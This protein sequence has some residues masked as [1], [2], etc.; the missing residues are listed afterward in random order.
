MSERKREMKAKPVRRGRRRGRAGARQ[1]QNGRRGRNGKGDSKDV[2]AP[3]AKT[4]VRRAQRPKVTP[5]SNGDSRVVH[6]E[7]IMD[8]VAGAGTPSAFAV[9]SLPVNPGQV[10]T[11]P[12]LS[13][14]AANYES[15]RF[16]SLRFCYETEASTALGGSLILAFDYDAADPA[17]TSK[18]QALMYRSSVRSAPWT[19]CEHKSILED[20]RKAKSNYV[21]PGAQP[22][23]TDVRQYDIGNFFAIS[24]G[25]STAGA[26]L[27][28]LYVEYNVVLMT[29][30]LEGSISAVFV[31]GT[32]G[33]DGTPTLANPFGDGVNQLQPFAYGF[34][35][36]SLSVLN[37]PNAGTYVISCHGT[38]TGI[39]GINFDPSV[40]AVTQVNQTLLASAL[41]G[42]WVV[43][44]VC[45]A[46]AT[47]GVDFTA[48]ATTI[49]ALE[50]WIGMAPNG[51]IV[52]IP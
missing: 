9:Q 21:R 5:F 30:V 44:F 33:T 11:F 18:Q 25:V 46:P 38:G 24:Q 8:L 39:T 29:P 22:A 31:G 13:R 36:N 51:S 12:W 2:Y 16:D 23:G 27:G 47:L 37:F 26:T 32:V 42:V 10:S 3:V 41:E 34:T 7:Y 35:V 19:A 20:L 17:P 45:P 49:D 14:I 40:G 6:R 28:E 1:S 43:E 50:M 4:K 15:Y 48:A 52:N